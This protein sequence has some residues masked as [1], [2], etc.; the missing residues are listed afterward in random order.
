MVNNDLVTKEIPKFYTGVSPMCYHLIRTS[1]LITDSTY[2]AEDNGSV[3]K[4][5]LKA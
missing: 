1:M 3:V 2:E 5:H 4:V